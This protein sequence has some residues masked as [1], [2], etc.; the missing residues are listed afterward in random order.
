M[1]FY[2]WRW[3]LRRIPERQR[4][5]RIGACADQKRALNP[6]LHLIPAGFKQSIM[7]LKH[8]PNLKPLA[9]GML[10]FAVPK[11]GT[12][13]GYDNPLGTLAADSCYSIF[14][15]HLCLPRDAHL[16]DLPKIVA[17]LGPGTN[18]SRNRDDVDGPC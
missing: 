5:R 11:L 4:G 6:R 1:D 16:V 14:L 7:P 8:V 9:K 3:T 2:S 13:N 15:R 17:E 10:S 18:N 12:V